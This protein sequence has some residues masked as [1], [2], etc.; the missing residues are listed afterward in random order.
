MSVESSQNGYAIV[1][2]SSEL[3][4]VQAVSIIGSIAAMSEIPVDVFVTMDGLLAFEKETVESGD[5]DVGPVGKRMLE[6]EDVDVPLFPEQMAQA[7][8]IGPMRVF[9]CSMAM[10]LMGR[11]MDDYI[12]VFD[13]E[14]GVAGFLEKA[15]DKQ[16]IF[17]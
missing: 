13:D 7:K 17:V 11:S 4:R 8:E 12:D 16:V 15:A 14:L 3:A 9:A 2:A 6:A 10:D 1:L 5:F